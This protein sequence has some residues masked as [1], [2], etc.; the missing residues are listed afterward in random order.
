L[1]PAKI[2]LD[3]DNGLTGPV[4]DVDDALALAM[5]LTSPEVHLLG[6]TACAGNC[7]TAASTVNTLRLLETAGAAIVPVAAGREAPLLRDRQPHWDYLAAK[8]T[9]PEGRFWRELSAP[10]A[11]QSSPDPLKA[12]E[13]IIREVNTHPGEV[14]VV[15]LGSLT[16]LALALLAA[17]DIGPRI[18]GVVH[19]GGMFAPPDG[20][21]A[22]RTPDIPDAVWRTSLRF[23]TLFDPEAAAVVLRSDVPVTLVT[24]NVTARVFWR[25]EHQAQLGRHTTGL[26]GFLH[27]WVEPWLEWSRRVRRLPGAHL[28]DPLTLGVVM[29]PGFCRFAELRVDVER[30]LQ[31]K[32]DWLAQGGT[33]R[34]VRAAVEV[35]AERFEAFL[36]ER[37]CAP[38]RPRYRAALCA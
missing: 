28:H 15:A 10:P 9:G 36:A 33:G 8:S 16:N 23:N 20:A 30:L 3:L 31:E 25:P 34:P 14:Q 22:W 26:Q 19:M 32:P 7:P 17:P 29:D 21:A 2:I 13:F 27:R 38:V 1:P 4:Q 37:L 11:P 24:V 18:K 5:A 12:H 6:C 35:A